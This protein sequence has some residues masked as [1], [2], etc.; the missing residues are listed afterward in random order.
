MEV[1]TK[2]PGLHHIL[3]EILMELDR[4]DL[5]KCRFVNEI[6]SNIVTSKCLK[7][8]IWYDRLIQKCV[9][10]SQN[11]RREWGK[12]IEKISECGDSNQIV[13]MKSYFEK[14]KDCTLKKFEV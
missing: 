1:I 14:M 5:N 7:C 2:S 3:E 6:W 12:L 8:L 4:E 11:E 13:Y 9:T 10:L